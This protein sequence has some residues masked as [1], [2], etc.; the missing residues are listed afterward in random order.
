MN[1]SQYLS[2]KPF[3]NQTVSN[4]STSHPIINNANQYMYEQKFV[5]IH[6]ED[7][8]IK[9]Y[10]NPSEFDI[11]MPQDYC[12]VQAVKLSTWSFPSTFTVFSAARNNISLSFKFIEPYNPG[13]YG[14]ADPLLSAMF[15]ALYDNIN[16][17]YIITIEEGTYTN[18]YMA[19]ELTNKMNEVV[20]LF[21]SNYLVK[22]NQLSLLQTFTNNGGYEEFVIIYHEVEGTF[23]FGNKSSSFELAND[24][25]IYCNTQYVCMNKTV[26]HASYS[27]W[28]LPAYLGFTKQ[29]LTSVDSSGS[30]LPKL[31][32]LPANNNSWLLPENGSPYHYLNTNVFYLKSPLKANIFG[33]PYFYMELFGLNSI[34]EMIPYVD[35]AFTRESNETNGTLNAAFAKLSKQTWTSS[36]WT[37]NNSNQLIPVRIFNP[38]AERIKKL[39]IKFREHNGQLLDLG[40]GNFSFT[41]EFTLYKPQ[42]ERKTSMFIPETTAYS[43]N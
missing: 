36:D 29:P 34:D 8:D 9:K 25:S 13:A 41:L 33:N 5:S 37:F 17:E 16:N 30:S 7:R 23:W 28:G 12:N 35:T 38:P 3:I 10:P 11:E 43:Y 40:V 32:Y 20:T 6:S 22:T 18:T 31:Y 42:I 26:V 2:Q 19:T 4:L 24:S 21:I 39:R 15:L 14:S 27:D 1:P